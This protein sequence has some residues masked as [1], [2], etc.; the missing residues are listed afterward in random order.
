MSRKKQMLDKIQKL[1]Y[2]PES[3]RNI[4][5]VAHID[6]GKTT[7]SDN[8]LAGAGMISQELAGEQLY[9]DFDIQEQTRGITIDAANVSMVHEYKDDEY[10]INM[11][12]TPGHV[13]FGGDVTRAMRAVDGVVVVVDAVEGAMPQTETV[14]RQ[15]LK[16]RVKPI[17]FVNKVD[18]L[19]NELRLTPED[20]QK[21]FIAIIAEFNKLVRSM[22]PPEFKKEWQVN[23][24]DGSV[25]FGSALNNWAISIP[26]MKVTGISFKDVIDYNMKENQAE[27]AKKAKM[28]EILLDMVIKHLPNPLT[29]QKYRIPSVWPGS[30][31]SEEGKTMLNCDTHGKLAMMVTS[32]S[33][34]PH[35]GEVAT[36]R[37]FSGDLEK[38]K[39]VYLYNMKGKA[40]IQQVGVYMGP[41]RIAT[42]HVPAGNIVAITGLKNAMAGETISDA[43][44][45]IEPFEEM[46][47]TSE[48][49]VTVAVEAKNMSDLPKLIEVLKQ[50][51]K[52]DPTIKIEI[53]EETGEHLVSGM[54]EL[55]LEVTAYRVKEKGVDID[56]S[57]PIVVYRESVEAT[58]QSVEGK[59]P[60]KHNKFYIVV[61]PLEKNIF[62]AIVEGDI[63]PHRLKGKELGKALKE[64]G[65]NKVDAKGAVQVL[66]NNLLTTVTKGIQYLNEVIGLIQEGYKDAV[67]AGPLAKERVLGIKVKLVDTKLHEDSIH[68]GPAQVIPAVRDAIREATLGAKA[69]LL[70]PKQKV[71]IQVPSDYMG[72]ATREIQSRRGQIL[73]MKQEGDMSTIIAK[74][75]VA[76]MFGFAGDIRSATEG[77]ALWSTE[78]AGFEKV[79]K[80]LQDKIIK[81]IRSRKGI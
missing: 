27:L 20:M 26:I 78:H 76:E 72:A 75:P 2:Q 29:A 4:G 59:S 45:P 38:G 58:S 3:I 53:D 60:N 49:V 7:L 36:G 5:I 11:I 67:E 34:D 55:H 22:A 64:L 32:M 41:D 17:L 79:P 31:E 65:M 30:L 13:D 80:E 40:R 61:E 50:V 46:K 63:K 48:P 9:L 66:N 54:G 25:A 23:V 6:H 10:L 35:A 71:F 12:D 81:E 62:D 43:D 42:D 47:H 39:E 16:E 77:R 15:A 1:M 44:T 19:I 28:H 52:A 8:L 33:I 18:R 21:R 70:E 73:D 74:C 14:I 57:K 37:I 68:R 51:S 69:T 56:V 24:D